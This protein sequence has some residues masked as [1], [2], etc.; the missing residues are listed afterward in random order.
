MNASTSHNRF[1][2]DK[3][4]EKE[5]GIDTKDEHNSLKTRGYIIQN[6]IG[7]GSYSKVKKAFSTKLA[8]SVAMKIVDRT[9]VP[10]TFREKFLPREIEVCRQLVFHVGP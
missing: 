3:D 2:A 6:A 10:K 1:N 5:R 9:K 8:K 7:E 4:I